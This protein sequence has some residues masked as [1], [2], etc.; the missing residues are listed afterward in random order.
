MGYTDYTQAKEYAI[1]QARVLQKEKSPKDLPLDLNTS[2]E[3]D[4]G[5]SRKKK[6]QMEEG[7]PERDEQ[8]TNEEL[9]A[10]IG[11]GPGKGGKSSPKGGKGGFQG[12]C[13][14]CGTYGH[15]INECRKKD[16]DMKG[17]GK[18]QSTQLGPAWGNPNPGKGKSKGN[19]GCWS[20]G[21]G[22]GGKGEKGAYHF[23]DDYS[24]GWSG[25]S[26]EDGALL[27]LQQELMGEWQEASGPL[28]RAEEDVPM[29]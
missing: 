8:Y 21:K 23:M 22:F 10:W 20:P 19:K 15:R 29:Q 2:T 25:Y 3:E 13:H 27:S 6:G 1:R 14:Y 18:G 11:K 9:L 16:A 17:K 28:A 12:N 26:F 4:T 7:T 5:E 24:Q